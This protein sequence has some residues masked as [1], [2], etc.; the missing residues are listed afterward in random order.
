MNVNGDKKEKK[1]SIEPKIEKR[2]LYFDK[3]KNIS[4]EVT[5]DQKTTCQIIYNENRNKIIDIVKALNKKMNLPTEIDLDEEIEDE[6]YY[7]CM[8]NEKDKDNSFVINLKLDLNEKLHYTFMKNP[9]Y[10]LC[11]LKKN[12]AKINL[13]KKARSLFVLEKDIYEDTEDSNLKEN[14]VKEDVGKEILFKN[15]IFFYDKK[16]QNFIKKDIT[17]DYERMCIPREN[18]TLYINAI[19]DYVYFLSESEERKKYEIKG[20]KMFGYIIITKNDNDSFIIASKKEYYFKKLLNSVKCVVNNLRISM[21]E[22]KIDNDIYSVKSGLFATHHLIID[23]CFLIKEILSNDE[24]RKIFLDCFPQKKIGEIID[25]IIEYKA[26]NKKG[27]FLESWTDF[28]QILAYLRP[29]ENKEIEF[30]K[31]PEDGDIN[32]FINIIGKVNLSKYNE[33]LEQT[34]NALQN[35]MIEIKNNNANGENIDNYNNAETQNS[36]NMSLKEILTENLFDELF[37]YLYNLYVLPFFESIVKSLKEGESPENQSIT[38][39][40]FQLLLSFYYFKF[41]DSKFIYL[42]QS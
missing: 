3:E 34:N 39:K 42:G 8:T 15:T 7:F 29:Y 6:N 14:T 12:R 18:I 9:K 28:K 1:D 38:R 22:L 40:K 23:N 13:R 10:D 5:I 27:L 31:R 16:L 25:K 35:A 2:R 32:E 41:F 4:I 26:L 19:K 11:F 37:Y 20:D 36:L 21:T 17:I 33:V 30:Q 24:K